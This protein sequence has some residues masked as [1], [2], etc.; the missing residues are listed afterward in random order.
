M[1]RE[2]YEQTVDYQMSISIVRDFIEEVLDGDI[3]KLRDFCFEDLITYEDN[4]SDYIGSI[5]DPD[6][7]IITRAI[8]II[9]W[10]DIYNLSF[11][12]MGSWNWMNEYA[13]RG[14]TMNSFNTVFGRMNIEEGKDFAWRA[15]LYGAHKYPE[16]WEKIKEFYKLYHSIGNFI[17]IPNRG[18][19]RNGINGARAGYSSKYTCESMR[20]YFDWFLIALYEYQ[21]KVLM[22]NTCF[23]KFELQLQMNPEY[24]PTFLNIEEWEERFFLMPYFKNGVP[25]QL[26]NTPIEDRLK[27]V[28]PNGNDS[29]KFYFKRDEYLE[30]I[31]DYIDKSKEVI[32]YRTDKIIEVLRDK[33]A[34]EEDIQTYDIMNLPKT[35]E[36]FEKTHKE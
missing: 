22:E 1:I 33:L 34:I 32:D 19:I 6:M 15:K 35:Y 16:L 2:R 4:I 17:V 28:D 29:E 14:D 30:L 25:R 7:Y 36:D 9:L 18:R 5:E 8:Y 23:N 11:S 10:G 26:F 21:Q 3:E 13:F 31:E 27:A 12:K 20:D 24:L